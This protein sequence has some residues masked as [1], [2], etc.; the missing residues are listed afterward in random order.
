M[1]QKVKCPRCKNVFSLE[2]AHE[3]EIKNLKE[4]AKKEALSEVQAE[5]AKA[6]KEKNKM[7]QDYEKKL[8]TQL[9]EHSLDMKRVKEYQSNF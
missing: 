6:D 1:S 5:K 8:Q 3:N 7:K 9:K 4:K 2:D